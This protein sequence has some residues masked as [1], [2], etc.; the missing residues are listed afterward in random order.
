MTKWITQNRITQ[1]MKSIAKERP[2]HLFAAPLPEDLF[3]WHFTIT[4]P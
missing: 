1:E 2:P 3:K 4:G